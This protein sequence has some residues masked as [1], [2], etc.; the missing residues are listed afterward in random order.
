MVF[1]LAEARLG[2]YGRRVSFAAILRL[3]MTM[4]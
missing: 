2:D 4:S 1:Q 3:Q